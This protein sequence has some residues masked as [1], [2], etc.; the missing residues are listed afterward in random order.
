MGAM[1]IHRSR[2]Q[3]AY[4]VVTPTRRE[5]LMADIARR[6]RRYLSVI[7][8]CLTLVVVGFFVP[9]PT[10]LRVVTLVVAASLAPA[11]VIAAGSRPHR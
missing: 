3:Q 9:L 4:D 2:R 6:R 7:V 1:G 8:P 5:A 11:A 10:A